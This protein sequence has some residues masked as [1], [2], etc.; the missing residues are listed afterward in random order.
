MELKIFLFCF[1]VS[2]AALV[3]NYFQSLHK[4]ISVDILLGNKADVHIQLYGCK[5]IKA[6]PELR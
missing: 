2:F 5:R 1:C 4:I 3:L 6:Y